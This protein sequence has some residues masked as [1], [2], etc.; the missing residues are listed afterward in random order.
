MRSL[1]GRALGAVAA[2]LAIASAQAADTV[3]QAAAPTSDARADGA[4]AKDDA[5]DGAKAGTKT[6]AGASDDSDS[7]TAADRAAEKAANEPNVKRT[8]I[9]DSSARIE[10]LRVRGQLQKVTV[11]PKDG[12]PGYEII[13]T[14][15][16]PEQAFSA[17]QA[18][19]RGSSG[20][21]VWNLLQF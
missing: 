16:S 21:R 1:T 20:K 7:H 4:K 18:G 17:G 11:H 12:A 13:I 8:V 5:K 19:S 6:E 15:G 2:L 9:D 14:S 10:E 3:P